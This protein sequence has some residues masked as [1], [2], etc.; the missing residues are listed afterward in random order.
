MSFLRNIIPA[1]AGSVALNIIHELARK[2]LKNV[3]QI[4]EIA[5]EGIEKVWMTMGNKPPEGKDLYGAAL[6]G[7]IV[8]NTAFFRTIS[9]DTPQETW[10]KGILLGAAA[11]IG[12]LTLSEPLGLN[13]KHVNRNRKVQALTILYYLIGGLVTA[14]VYNAIKRN[15]MP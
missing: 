3:P 6:A 4:N 10:I 14:G 15:S 2:Q 12:A 9:G 13:D 1:L 8:A 7:D 11:G 5:E